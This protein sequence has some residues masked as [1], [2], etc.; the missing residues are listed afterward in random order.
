MK[1]SMIKA[2]AFALLVGTI[3]HVAPLNAGWKELLTLHQG[4]VAAISVILTAGGITYYLT[5]PVFASLFDSG[6]LDRIGTKYSEDITD[7]YYHRGYSVAKHK[8]AWENALNN[9]FAHIDEHCLGEGFAQGRILRD[10][11]QVSQVDTLAIFKRLMTT[12]N[13][14]F[15]QNRETTPEVDCTTLVANPI[16]GATYKAKFGPP[17]ESNNNTLLMTISCVVPQNHELI[18]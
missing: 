4:K 17:Q 5:R 8:T 12:I 3:T 16:P 10:K 1:K 6:G 11:L 13:E 9:A 7:F 14:Q 15:L 2:I 18:C